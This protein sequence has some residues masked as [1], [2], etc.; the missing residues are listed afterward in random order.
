MREWNRGDR[1]VDGRIH[2]YV[3]ADDQKHILNAA[4][5]AQ[6]LQ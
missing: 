3:L 1:V 6:R 5:G 4:G 2:D